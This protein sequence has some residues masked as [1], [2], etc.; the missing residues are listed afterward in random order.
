MLGWFIPDFP[1]LLPWIP[2]MHLGSCGVLAALLRIP[3]LLER[4]WETRGCWGD[5][6]A[7]GARGSLVVDQGLFLVVDQ[8]LPPLR[9]LRRVRGQELGLEDQDG[10]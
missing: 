1:S 4:D 8:E 2:E 10:V 3:A 9:E 6:A 7:L 5:L